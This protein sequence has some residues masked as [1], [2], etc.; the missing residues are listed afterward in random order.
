MGKELSIIIPLKNRTQIHCEYEPIQEKTFERHTVELSGFKHKPIKSQGK[1]RLNL[2]IN[3]LESLQKVKEKDEQFEIVIV[4]FYSNDYDLNKLIKKFKKLD[5]KIIKVNDYFSRGKGLN[6][7]YENSTKPNVLFCDADMYF[8]K[9][10]LFDAAYECFEE[11]KILFP[12]CFD[13]CEPTH[14]I[15][16]WRTSGYGISAVSKELYDDYR[17]SEYNSLG[18]EDNDIWEHFNKKGCT[19]RGKIDGYYH[20]WHPP[21]VTFKNKYYKCSESIPKL[22]CANSSILTFLQKRFNNKRLYFVNKLEFKT[23]HAVT[24]G[25]DIEELLQIK[26]FLLKFNKELKVYFILQNNNQELLLN[27]ANVFKE[28]PTLLE[29]IQVINNL[30]LIKL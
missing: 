16:Y 24:D 7:G 27:L 20:Q 17:Q 21:T 10:D 14:Q 5:I 9:H 23:T 6:I 3:C 4:D 26:E 2:L 1:I 22:Y 15:G 29:K 30:E 12:I 19:V 8:T 25:Y 18:K 11:G 28:E 13:L